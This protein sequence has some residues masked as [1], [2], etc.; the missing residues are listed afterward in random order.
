[1]FW[2]YLASPLPHHGL[3]H[4]QI[5]VVFLVPGTQLELQTQPVFRIW[6]KTVY[7]RSCNSFDNNNNMYLKS[8]IQTSSIDIDRWTYPLQ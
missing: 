6:Y 3:V 8:S 5:S 2:V 7:I 4:A 1:M